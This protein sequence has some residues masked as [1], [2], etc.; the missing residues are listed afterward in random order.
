MREI[1]YIGNVTLNDIAFQY[2]NVDFFAKKISSESTNIYGGKTTKV[3]GWQKNCT[4][5][6]LL[7]NKTSEDT[8]LSYLVNILKQMK[9]GGVTLTVK[10]YSEDGLSIIFNETFDTLNS[11]IS[12]SDYLSDNSKIGISFKFSVFNSEIVESIPSVWQDTQDIYILS[13]DIL[14]EDYTVL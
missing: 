3:K 5:E 6:L 14:I 4:I 8:N 10:G 2:V 9:R 11:N 13:D 1:N 12:Y 7:T